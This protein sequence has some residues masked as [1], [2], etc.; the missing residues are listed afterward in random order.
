MAVTSNN[1][2]YLNAIA[3]VKKN[4]QK[5]RDFLFKLGLKN[6]PVITDLGNGLLVSFLVERSGKFEY[7]QNRQILSEGITKEKILEIGLL[8]L[9]KIAT[10]N[11]RIKPMKSIFAVFVDGNFE[12]SLILIPEL[13][14]KILKSHI[15]NKFVVA[16]PTRDMLVFCDSESEEGIRELNALCKRVKNDGDRLLSDI[17]YIRENNSWVEYKAITI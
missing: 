16:I 3:Y 12:A 10:K 11:F 9:K 5:E 8:N 14:E 4:D 15:N 17:L 1:S 7:L 6:E 13:W 2:D